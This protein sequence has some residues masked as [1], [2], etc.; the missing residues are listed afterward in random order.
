MRCYGSM[1]GVIMCICWAINI[2]YLL[3]HENNTKN[4]SYDIL[5]YALHK[6]TMLC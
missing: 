2:F 4:A 6:M 5:L 1:Y 3:D